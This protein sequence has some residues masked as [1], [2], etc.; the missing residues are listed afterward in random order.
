MTLVLGLDVGNAKL[1]LCA[2]RPGDAPRWSSVTLPY[3]ARRPYARHADFAAGVPRAIRD[4]VRGEAVTCAVAVTSA[5][6]SYPTFADGVRHL[7]KVL[8]ACLPATDTRLLS[9][10]GTAVPTASLRSADDATVAPLAFTNPMGAVV[11]TRQEALLGSPAWGLVLDTGGSTTGT[12]VLAGETVDPAAL[13]ERACYTHYRVRTGRLAWTGVQTTPL[14]SLAHE[15]TLDGCTLPI[16]PRGVS[17]ENVAVL[18]ICFRP[19]V[20]QS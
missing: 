2:A 6:Y 12:L 17:F 3:D 13:E 10:G 19:I 7:A 9:F 14:E 15:V 20:L 11:L 8:E 16:V 5:G 18:P 1:K 4:L